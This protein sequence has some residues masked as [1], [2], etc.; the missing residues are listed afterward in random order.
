MERYSMIRIARLFTLLALIM[1]ST[2][3]FGA[4]PKPELIPSSPK[5]YTQA[6]FNKARLAYYNRVIVESYKKLGTHDSKW[7]A[8][9]TTF[10]QHYC[11]GIVY[12]HAMSRSKEI[13]EEGK[14]VIA[15]GC[16][17]PMVQACTGM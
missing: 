6:Q 7:D 2:T 11:E 17:D 1:C 10:L 16:S 15:S 13:A 12:L 3:V 8:A 4:A 5:A 9:A 14:A